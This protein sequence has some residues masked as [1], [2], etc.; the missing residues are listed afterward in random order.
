LATKIAE[1][2]IQFFKNEKNIMLISRLKNAGLQLNLK[3]NIELN[4]SLFTGQSIVVSG[5]FLSSEA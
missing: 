5:S 4:S 2:H 1:K 3:E